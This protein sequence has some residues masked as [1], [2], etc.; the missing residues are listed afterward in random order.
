MRQHLRG[1]TFL[2]AALLPLRCIPAQDS[3]ATLSVRGDIQKPAQWS[4]E[5]LKAQF[6]SQVQSVK[7]TV[8]WPWVLLHRL[9]QMQR[10]VVQ[11]RL[12]SKRAW[13]LNKLFGSV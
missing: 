2:A 10:G 9:D 12:S 3:A 7:F 6:A 8:G 4:V 13:M 5:A 1:L 11:E